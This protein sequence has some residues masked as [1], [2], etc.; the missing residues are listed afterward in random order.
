[1]KAFSLLG[2]K[3]EDD[4]QLTLQSKDLH[5]VDQHRTH[6][7][8]STIFSMDEAHVSRVNEIAATPGTLKIRFLPRT[9][10]NW[11]VERALMT[12]GSIE[13]SLK[14]SRALSRTSAL[15]PGCQV[16]A[17]ADWDSSL[18]LLSTLIASS[19]PLGV[20][21]LVHALAIAS[22]E[23]N[24]AVPVDSPYLVTN[25]EVESIDDDMQMQLTNKTKHESSSPPSPFSGG[26][27]SHRIFTT[28]LKKLFLIPSLSI[29]R[30]LK[31]EMSTTQV[32][33]LIDA[34]RVEIARSGWLSPYESKLEPSD[35]DPQNDHQIC[36]IAHLLS[37]AIDSIGTGGWLLGT[38]MMDDFSD[39]A[40]TIAYMKAEISAAMEA[41]EEATY[42]K[43]ML[44]EL[45]LCGKDALTA[46]VRS[47]RPVGDS[48]LVA[49]SST[50]PIRMASE[51]LSSALPLGLRPA[52]T[53]ST[54]KIAA[55]GELRKRS[56]RDIGRQKSRAV[57]KYSFERIVI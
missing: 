39:S 40:D 17:F 30:A 45:L 14:R 12:P 36:H 53:T 13:Q 44:G 55:G 29:A 20:R 43:G 42:L 38:S 21:E 19:T 54:T 51:E 15:A 1:M 4:E 11:L 24:A 10:C 16:R 26:K 32:R 35:I 49:P 6:L 8:L 7:I 50:G 46:Q 27:Y 2:L 28:V 3:G 41:I 52:Q 56:K 33:T 18:E 47:S 25:G 9:I 57:G 5:C 22:H 48:K 31:T 37:C 34:L 23:S